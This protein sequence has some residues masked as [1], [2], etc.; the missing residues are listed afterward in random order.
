MKGDDYPVIAFKKQ[1]EFEEFLSKNSEK[2]PGIWLKFAR[3]GS[4]LESI[5]GGEALE[6][7]LCFGWID[8]QAA[9]FDETYYL[10]KYTP[11][12]PRSLWSM[13]NVDIANRLIKEKRMRAGGLKKIEEAKKDGRWERAYGGTADSKIP[14]DFLN[15]L[16]KD[17][18]AYEFFLTLKKA[19]LFAIYFRL[20]TAVKPETRERRKQAILEL[21]RLGK[22]IAG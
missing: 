3:K 6:V 21:L 5:T 1:A 11:R 7:A 4:G 10:N 8:G 19:D 22:K 18:K 16:K 13:R 12:G 20:H 15:E 14:E 9:S 17:A 2:V